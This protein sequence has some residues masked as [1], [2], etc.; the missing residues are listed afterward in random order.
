M[1][2]LLVMVWGRSVIETLRVGDVLAY[3]QLEDDSLLALRRV[4]A[5]HKEGSRGVR[6]VGGDVWIMTKSDDLRRDDRQLR[7]SDSSDM[8]FFGR[9]ESYP[10]LVFAYVSVR[11]LVFVLT[12]LS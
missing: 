1:V 2:L 12:R 10:G 4:T 9:D 7:L 11:F 5:V 3:R 8:Y 6:V